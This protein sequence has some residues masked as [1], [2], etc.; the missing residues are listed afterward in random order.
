MRQNEDTVKTL[1]TTFRER[2]KKVILKK[3]STLCPECIS[4][5]KHI[6]RITVLAVALTTIPTVQILFHVFG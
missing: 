6:D 4:I 5:E 3:K 1:K 2:V